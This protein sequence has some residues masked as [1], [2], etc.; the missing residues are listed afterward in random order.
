MTYVP[1]L[2]VDCNPRYRWLATNPYDSED[3]GLAAMLVPQTKEVNDILLFK[4]HQHGRRDVSC[5][6][7]IVVI[8]NTMYFMYDNL[9][10]RR[11]ESHQTNC[12]LLL[13]WSMQYTGLMYCI[14]TFY[15][16]WNTTSEKWNVKN[17]KKLPTVNKTHLP[18]DRSLLAFEFC[19]LYAIY[20]SYYHE[21]NTSTMGPYRDQK[22]WRRTTF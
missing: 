6:S 5:K 16:K 1:Y 20:N 13:W 2:S 17:V 11:D 14:D 10:T 8:V 19:T 3:K 7:S 21:A 9:N 4:F 18:L 12:I 22:M 15:F